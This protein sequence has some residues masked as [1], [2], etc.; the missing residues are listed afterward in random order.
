MR[1][2]CAHR[3]RRS[4][5][6]NIQSL[7]S[8]ATA[9]VPAPRWT[10]RRSA[11]QVCVPRSLTSSPLRKPARPTRGH[12]G[13]RCGHGDVGIASART[14]VPSLNHLCPS[15]AFGWR[16]R[17]MLMCTAWKSRPLSPEQTDR[18]MATWGKIEAD[19]AASASVERVCWFISADG[20]GGLAVNRVVD[21]DRGRHAESR[22]RPVTGRVPRV[23]YPTGAGPRR[24]DVSD[25]QGRG[26]HQGLT[27]RSARASAR[28]D[29][30]WRRSRPS[31][32]TPPRPRGVE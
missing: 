13:D 16:E 31:S 2:W 27:S 9:S 1:S 11:S 21:T 19:Q 23:G 4:S 29:G 10:R 15:W 26:A 18:M 8:S 32:E 6:M 25:H 3:S 5:W 14:V 22:I 17:L 28:P 24:G 20:A 30:S 7:R 12:P